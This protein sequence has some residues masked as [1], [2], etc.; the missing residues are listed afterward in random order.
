MTDLLSSEN[1]QQELPAHAA[2]PAGEAVGRNSGNSRAP[3]SLRPTFKGDTLTQQTFAC[4]RCQQP[5]QQLGSGWIRVRGMRVHVCAACK[6]TAAHRAQRARVNL[7]EV[8]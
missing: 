3:F 4:S 5:S 8:A 1:F 7:P 2:T 6:D